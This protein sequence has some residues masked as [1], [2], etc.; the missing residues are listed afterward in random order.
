MKRICSMQDEG[1]GLI[2]VVQ[3][4]TIQCKSLY[5]DSNC[6]LVVSLYFGSETELIQSGPMITANT[7]PQSQ[8]SAATYP[9][10]TEQ[11]YPNDHLLQENQ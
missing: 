10:S 2:F 5:E 7:S 4:D 11:I 6:T 3:F 1:S 9:Q 8:G